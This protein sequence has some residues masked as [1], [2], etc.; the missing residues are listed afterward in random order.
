MF[1]CCLASMDNIFHGYLEQE[2][3]K[4][5]HKIMQQLGRYA[6]TSDCQW[7]LIESLVRTTNLVF[8]SSYNASTLCATST[9]EERGTFH[10]NYQR[11]SA[12]RFSVL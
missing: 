10:T 8:C 4:K 5:Y 6:T 1:G 2:Q 11:W 3:V 9:I 7:K 12:V